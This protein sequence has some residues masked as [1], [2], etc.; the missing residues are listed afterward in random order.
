MF[1]CVFF[2]FRLLHSCHA[3]WLTSWASLTP[4]EKKEITNAKRNNQI[5]RTLKTNLFTIIPSFFSHIIYTNY[6]LFSFSTNPAPSFQVRRDTNSVINESTSQ[7]LSKE[8]LSNWKS[9]NVVPLVNQI[10]YFMAQGL[11]LRVKYYRTD[12]ELGCFYRIT[13]LLNIFTKHRE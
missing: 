5:A 7:H 11:S 1:Y 10:H 8:L 4:V 13:R 12:Q 6:V 9:W 2:F 3:C